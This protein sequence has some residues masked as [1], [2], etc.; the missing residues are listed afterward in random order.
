MTP[1]SPA[2]PTREVQVPDL[3]FPDMR[4]FVPV[5]PR[6]TLDEYDRLNQMWK[7]FMPPDPASR[8]E[9][10]IHEEFVLK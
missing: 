10:I 1:K 3:E 5:R 8:S 7:D 9:N 4:D 6:L 2:P